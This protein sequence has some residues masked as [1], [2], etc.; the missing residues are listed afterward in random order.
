MSAPHVP[1]II[2]IQQQFRAELAALDARAAGQMAAA[3]SKAFDAVIKQLTRLLDQLETAQAAGEPITPA[4]LYREQR[5][6]ILLATITEQLAQYAS[7]ATQSTILA[8]ADG[9]DLAVRHATELIT[10]QVDQ[11]TLRQQLTRQLP[12]ISTRP[13][14][15][16]NL[17]GTLGNGS[18]LRTLFDG[19]GSE[20][21]QSARDILT[22][23][24]A[25]GQNPRVTARQMK[26]AF[27]GNLVRSLTVAR[28]ET[29][30]A[31]RTAQQQMYR[32]PEVSSVVQGWIWICDLSPRTCAACLA[33]NGTIH[34]LD[35]DFGSHPNCRCSPSPHVVRS[36]V[37]IES[38]ADWL[39][40]QPETT[41]RSI[42][43]P[44]GLKLYQDG[45]PLS[46]FVKET[47]SDA[48]GTSRTVAPLRDIAS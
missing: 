36:R 47:H 6:R 48:W 18:P 45:A 29:T 9:I 20:A 42:L 46:A 31:Y 25:T 13:E 15:V 5:Y 19:L 43:G 28:T 14:V 2:A 24:V 33:M 1:D 21:S 4:Q 32:Q 38:G 41:Q 3:F 12:L 35:E 7:I 30:R 10:T 8:Q 11:P 26:D 44:G 17:V 23:A 37:K 39:A 16:G 40:R 22:A 34:P 27:G